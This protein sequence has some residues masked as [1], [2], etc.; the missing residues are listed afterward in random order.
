MIHD[1]YVQLVRQG[2]DLG[3]LRVSCPPARIRRKLQ[4]FQ[5][6]MRNPTVGRFIAF[7]KR[8]GIEAVRV[9]PTEVSF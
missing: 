1:C 9:R 5:E 7:L 6:T 2:R 3:I 8:A 4:R